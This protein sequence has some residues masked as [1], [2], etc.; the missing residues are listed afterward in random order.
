MRK[1]I[2]ETC[3][4]KMGSMRGK[5]SR[6]SIPMVSICSGDGSNSRGSLN[7]DRC[8]DRCSS[9][10]GNGG[11]SGGY[12]RGNMVNLVVGNRRGNVVNVGLDLVVR[13]DVGGF[14]LNKSFLGED[15]LGSN[16][17]VRNVFGGG[18]GS[19]DNFSN[20]SGFMDKGGL[21]NGVGQSRNLRG[22]LSVSM[23]F[24]N[25]VSKVAT[26]TVRFN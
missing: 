6:G 10:I 26:Q 19:G 20:G 17:W 24:S 8:S 25:S 3:I 22:H 12:N 23:R 11:Y 15:G 16:D 21:S 13:L 1:A 2:R 7:S 5:V 14:G 18:D 4:T 9:G